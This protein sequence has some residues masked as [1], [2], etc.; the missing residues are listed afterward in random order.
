MINKY[1][2]IFQWADYSSLSPA[3]GTRWNVHKHT[4]NTLPLACFHNLLLSVKKRLSEAH[5]G[6]GERAWKCLRN[7]RKIST[8]WEGE[9]EKQRCL[10]T[11]R[12][13]R[14]VGVECWAWYVKVN[15]VKQFLY[16]LEGQIFSRIKC[17]TKG[18]R[19]PA[20]NSVRATLWDGGWAPIYT[21]QVYAS[22]ARFLLRFGL[23]FMWQRRAGA[24]E[25][26]NVW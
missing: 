7:R 12:Q 15:F 26:G 23:L 6:R 21:L 8:G 4:L 5:R 13:G 19:N 3:K 24:P 2:F 14:Q 11:G 1:D 10:K 25:T 16:L 9:D 18:G 20:E 17:I 22:K